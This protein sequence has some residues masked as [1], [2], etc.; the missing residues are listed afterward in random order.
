M[1]T[2]FEST[3]KCNPGFLISG[4]HIRS[5]KTMKIWVDKR[6]GGRTLEW[7]VVRDWWLSVCFTYVLYANNIISK[8]LSISFPKKSQDDDLHF[9]VVTMNGR[10]T[11]HFKISS[12]PAS[13]QLGRQT[14]TTVFTFN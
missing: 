13:T 9:Y 6:R 4:H 7:N 8:I 12:E 14:M 10:Y 5:K 1:L 2:S 11:R 3:Q